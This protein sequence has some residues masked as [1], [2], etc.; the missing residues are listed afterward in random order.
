[1]VLVG[2]LGGEEAEEQGDVL[3]TR[4]Q[5]WD[6]DGDGIEAEEQIL[7]EASARYGLL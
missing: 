2:A 7:A 6:L 4:A 3:G 5:G 1:M